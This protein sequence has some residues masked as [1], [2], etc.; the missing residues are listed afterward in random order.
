MMWVKVT[1]FLFSY[2]EQDTSLTVYNLVWMWRVVQLKCFFDCL[3]FISSKIQ[4]TDLIC[5]YKTQNLFL[6]KTTFFYLSGWFPPFWYI[7]DNRM[8]H[9][10]QLTK[11]LRAEM[12][13]S[14]ASIR[15]S[16]RLL[17]KF[18]PNSYTKFPH[19]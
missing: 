16:N 12:I 5:F 19:T 13:S 9:E 17:L 4:Q 3:L 15:Q 10:L 11:Q 18:D 8:V 2:I 14:P 1:H 7:W 6:Y